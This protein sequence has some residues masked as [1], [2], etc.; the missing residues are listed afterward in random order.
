[1]AEN[2]EIV[3]KA[4]DQTQAG[5]ASASG[6]IEGLVG[7]IANL[8][9]VAEMRNIGESMTRNITQPLMQIGKTAIMTSADFEQGL[10]VLQ[11][12]TKA[13][14]EDMGLMEKQALDLGA[15]SVFG[16]LDVLE[17]QTALAKAGFTTQQTL[18]ATTGVI[19]LAAAGELGMVQASELLAAAINSFGLEAEDSTR[20][21][22]LL[23]A[24]ANASAVD[25]SDLGDSFINVASVAGAAGIPIEDVSTALAL[26]GN[27]GLV[28]AEAG[29]A[30]RTVLRQLTAPTDEAAQLMKELGIDVYN[31]AGE[32]NSLPSILGQLEQG[33]R[34]LTAEQA[35]HAKQTI[36]GSY[37][38]VA[39]T[40]LI[41]EGADAYAAMREQVTQAGVAQEAAAARMKGFNGAL[42]N[43][44]GAIETLMIEQGAPF[45]EML[46]GFVTWLSNV[47]EKFGNLPKPIQVTIIAVA[48]IAAALGPLLIVVSSIIGA[49]TT[50]APL[51]VAIGGVIA[52]VAGIISAPVIGIIA[53]V[54]AVVA[55]IA[56]LAKAWSENW[57]GIQDKTKA[58]V[59][60]IGDS[61]RGLWTNISGWF[62]EGLKNVTS[63]L[64]D[65]V[66]RIA[67]WFKPATWIDMGRDIVNGIAEGIKRFA[68]NIFD[69]LKNAVNGALNSVKNLLGI[70]SPSA[71]AAREIGLPF[72]QGIG[73]GIASG[74]P[75]AMRNVT[76]NNYWSVEVVGG[77]SAGQ[78]VRNT[79]EL[80]SALY[81]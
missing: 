77:A 76:N 26:L 73:A 68:S 30:L 39:G 9:S 50:L 56:F 75:A 41:N 71:V 44:K 25:V 28:G 52:T 55:G 53:V 62:S 4:T 78:D 22:D 8:S 61:I 20:V 15:S 5:I 58:A 21:A 74:M 81:G 36:L 27:N 37:G 11:Q 16:A 66:K 42:E 67:D 34:S 51:F 80:M 32:M 33:V 40:I 3:I 1:M 29:T 43:L 59:G 72:A 35:A 69:G 10:N 6:N 65:L 2:V 13:T 57:G 79:V 12:V 63:W 64:S 31:T 46:N 70:H 14:T 24:A 48:A 17:A 18:A 47:I 49:I 54:A 45:L 19:D 38:V 60:W 23:A 7:K